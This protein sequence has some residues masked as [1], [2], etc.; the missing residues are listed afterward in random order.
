MLYY[1]LSNGAAIEVKVEAG[2]ITKEEY[3]QWLY[4]YPEYDHKPGWVKT[5]P[6]QGLNDLIVNALKENK[7]WF[8][9]KQ[10]GSTDFATKVSRAIA[11]Y[12]T[13]C[14]PPVTLK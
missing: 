14:K 7:D 11:L 4:K 3:D 9:W 1:K 2:E 13:T 5:I 6:S 8:F 10:N 12:R